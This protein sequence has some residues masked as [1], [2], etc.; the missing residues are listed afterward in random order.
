MKG[1]YCS[2]FQ[3]EKKVGLCKVNLIV[4]VSMCSAIDSGY[5]LRWLYVVFL[6]SSS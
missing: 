3:S 1:E 6:I 4:Y 5:D 2:L